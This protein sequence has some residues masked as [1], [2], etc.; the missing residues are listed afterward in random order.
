M[1][2][3]AWGKPKQ[4]VSVEDRGR[5]LQQILQAIAADREAEK[6][7]ANILKEASPPAVND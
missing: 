6:A 5:T 1:A 7:S 2:A 3:G 4:D